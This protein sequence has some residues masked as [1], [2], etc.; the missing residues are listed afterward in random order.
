MSRRREENN[1]ADQ[2][3]S[4]AEGAERSQETE[5]RS[6]EAEEGIPEKLLAE[7]A[8]KLLAKD[9]PDPPQKKPPQPPHPVPEMARLPPQMARLL[10]LRPRRSRPHRSRPR[11]LSLR[12]LSPRLLMSP[13]PEFLS[14]PSDAPSP[15]GGDVT[16][17]GG[18]DETRVDPGRQQ[19][20]VADGGT[21]IPDKLEMIEAAYFRVGNFRIEAVAAAHCG[22]EQALL[23]ALPKELS[24]EKWSMETP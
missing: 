1:R 19:A 12:I 8:E 10:S 15:A 22:L 16:L 21:S 11:I 24:R 7:E 20:V 6:Q 3:I 4:R 2:E 14:P 13:P 5:E 23:T 18:G 17:F 9:P